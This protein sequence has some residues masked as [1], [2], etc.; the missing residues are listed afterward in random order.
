MPTG[1]FNFGVRV[2]ITSHR[3]GRLD[4]NRRTLPGGAALKVVAAGHRFPDLGFC[5]DEL[6]RLQPA[7]GRAARLPLP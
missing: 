4:L 3:I 7:N 5:H 6:G 2:N 1:R